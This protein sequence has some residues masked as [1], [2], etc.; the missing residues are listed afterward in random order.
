MVQVAV[1][2]AFD[3]IDNCEPAGHTLLI[4]VEPGDVAPLDA[5]DDA[6]T[7]VPVEVGTVIAVVPIV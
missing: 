4:S 5:V 2:V 6:I 1:L 7:K 3:M